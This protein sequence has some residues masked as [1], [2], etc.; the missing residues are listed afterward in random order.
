MHDL[1]SFLRR[2][3]A[4]PGRVLAGLVFAAFA[5]LPGAGLAQGSNPVLFGNRDFEMDWSL[6][7]GSKMLRFRY[8]GATQRLRIDMLDG[9]EQTMHRDLAKGH[10]VV[11]VANGTKGAFA[12][13]TRPIGAFQPEQI[14]GIRT[15]VGESCREF[16]AGGQTLC[17]T[18]DGIPVMVDFGNGQGVAQRL[19]RE[20][21]PVALFELPKGLKPKPLPGGAENSIP[22]GLF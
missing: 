15:I 2:C 8:H 20:T 6:Q 3:G 19:L 17:V 14:G 5:F 13:T 11:L 16:S 1:S 7:P 22:K 9:S 4:K 10:V 18:A 12:G 21:Q